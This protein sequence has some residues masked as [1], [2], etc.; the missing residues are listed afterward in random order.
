MVG[1]CWKG[2]RLTRRAVK[3]GEVCRSGGHRDRQTPDDGGLR[4][5]EYGHGKNLGFR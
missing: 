5:H 3:E 2:L 4:L 1:G